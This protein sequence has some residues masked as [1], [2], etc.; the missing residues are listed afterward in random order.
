MEEISCKILS[1]S[2]GE[3]RTLLRKSEV[4]RSQ[5]ME[6]MPSKMLSASVSVDPSWDLNLSMKR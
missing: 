2:A 4:E 6:G 1:K 5:V 3:S